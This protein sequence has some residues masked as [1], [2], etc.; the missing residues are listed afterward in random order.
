MRCPYEYKVIVHGDA[1]INKVTR[2][3]ERMLRLF[4][5][6]GVPVGYYV[7]NTIAGESIYDR[8]GRLKS[9]FQALARYK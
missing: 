6:D 1:K 7:V 8:T 2:A 9:S 3:P 5:Y 4:P